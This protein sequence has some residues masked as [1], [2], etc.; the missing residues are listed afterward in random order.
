[1][2]LLDG[3][4]A[5]SSAAPAA[6]AGQ[7][8]QGEAPKSGEGQTVDSLNA[9]FQAT[10]GAGGEA[11]SQEDSTPAGVE[12]HTND[13]K[14]P[15][16]FYD[17]NTPG[18][19]D[20]PEWLQSKFK[21]VAEAAKSFNELEKKFGKFKGAPE[22]Y[23]TSIPD[24]PDMKFEEGDPVL[25][26]FLDYAKESNAS[27]EFVTK[28]LSQ[29]VKSQQFYA[30]DPEAEMQK[31]GVNA[32]T[33]ITQ[34]SEWAGQRLTPQEHEVFKSLVTTA[35]A[36]RVLQKLKGNITSNPEIA[37][38]G[39]YNSQP[40]VT[41]REVQELIADPRFNTDALFRKEVEQKAAKIWG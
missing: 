33:E 1:M 22:E 16:W 2:S 19:G 9:Q 30:P 21:S 14:A 34:L 37:T 12:N 15:D 28:A 10:V 27:Q 35:E 26:E 29:F 38:K 41:E 20:R 4:P 7:S 32:Q 11:K 23:D 39:N 3:A 5:T 18:V 31:L 6:D 17:D 25:K 13:A 8:A 40:K 24:M 36:F